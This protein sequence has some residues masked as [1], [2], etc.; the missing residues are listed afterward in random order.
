MFKLWLDDVREAPDDDW[1]PFRRAEDLRN[2]VL[3]I[4]FSNISTIS[5]DHDLGENVWS[6]Y[7]FLKWME[8]W[9][10]GHKETGSPIQLDMH[11][12]IH[13]ANPVGRKN[14]AAAIESIQRISMADAT[15]HP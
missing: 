8:V 10:A 6:G 9:I 2:A 12:L 7:D 5:L 3:V 15:G 11:I 14:M 1:I 13:S 4:G